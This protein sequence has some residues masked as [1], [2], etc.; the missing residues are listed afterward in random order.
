ME[1]RHLEP[2][3]F[4]GLIGMDF[5]EAEQ[6]AFTEHN[7]F[8]LSHDRGAATIDGRSWRAV[9]RPTFVAIPHQLARF[10]LDAAEARIR[11]VTTAE[12]I[13]IAV[14]QDRRV[15]VDF[16]HVTPPDL[17]DALSVRTHAQKH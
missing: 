1:A 5:E 6:A 15:P 12:G 8:A 3:D 11:F 16:E 14:M 17:I 7:Q 9:R 10:E 4:F 13:E 2:T